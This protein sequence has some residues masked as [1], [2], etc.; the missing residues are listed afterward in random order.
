MAFELSELE[1]KYIS[2]P[3][4]TLPRQID[5]LAQMLRQ[6]PCNTPY[7]M[8]SVVCMII[9][10]LKQEADQ[11]EM[12]FIHNLTASCLVE[13]TTTLL[14][15]VLLLYAFV[16][17][18]PLRLSFTCHIANLDCPRLEN[19]E[20]Q[21]AGKMFALFEMFCRQSLEFQL[22]IREFE[23]FHDENASSFAPSTYFR[24]GIRA[25][26]LDKAQPINGD[27]LVKNI[28]HLYLEVNID[29]SSQAIN[30]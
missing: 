8:T 6:K 29:L 15:R 21:V 1:Q 14:T 11:P 5:A 26:F 28:L 10:L 23:S 4:T 20:S 9:A 19:S 24:S 17:Q 12:E 3:R 7:T 16:D 30:K 25:Q 22:W 27:L 2:S 13:L 18:G